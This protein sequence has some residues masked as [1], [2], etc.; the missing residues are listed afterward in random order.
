VYNGYIYVIGGEYKEGKFSCFLDDVYYAHIKEDGSIGNWKATTSLPFRQRGHGCTVHNGY[1]Y[2]TG[3]WFAGR[4]VSHNVLCASI[5]TDGTIGAWDFTMPFFSP[6]DNH[7]T[8]INKEFIYVIAG[9]RGNDIFSDIQY[10]TTK[11]LLSLIP[12]NDKPESTIGWD[13]K[14]DGN[15]K[16]DNIR[17]I[18]IDLNGNVYIAGIG[19]NLVSKTSSIDWWIKKFDSDGKEDTKNW[20]KKIDGNRDDDRISSIAIDSKGNIYVKGYS[21]TVAH[22]KISYYLW[23]KKF[24]K[25]GNEDINNWDKKYK[26]NKNKINDDSELYPFGSHGTIEFDSEDNVYIVYSGNAINETS[27]TDWI[28]KKFNDNGEED[29]ANWNK[30]FDGNSGYDLVLAITIDKKDNIYVSGFGQDLVSNESGYDF[31]IKKFDING[32]ED[33]KNWDKKIDGKSKGENNWDW[34]YSLAID[35]KNN[36]YVGGF[37]G[38][39]VSKKSSYD[40]WIKKFSSSGIEDTKN[41]DKKFDSK[42]KSDNSYSHSD[43]IYSIAIGPNGN[44]YIAGCGDSL[45]NK[46]S[47]SDW[48]IKKFDPNGIEDKVNWDKKIDNNNGSNIISSLAIDKNGDIYAAGKG[49]NLVSPMSGYD[50]WIKKFDSNGLEIKRIEPT[51]FI[52]K[53]KEIYLLSESKLLFNSLSEYLDLQLYEIKSNAFNKKNYYKYNTHEDMG[54]KFSV[55]SYIKS[56]KKK[57]KMY[58]VIKEFFDIKKK[59]I[60]KQVSKTTSLIYYKE[61][62]G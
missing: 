8:I 16:D 59:E 60:D 48:W 4:D 9:N 2:V 27:K 31:W 54:N 35:D 55:F 11:S 43:V 39:L 56:N 17:S 26:V 40:W 15:G 22:G 50:W 61:R 14:I 29:Q 30:K 52:Q 58:D 6:R 57:E 18:A 25:N 12:S 51:S 53:Y 41:W 28:I 13:K 20:D 33:T 49:Q 32:N 21:K 19:E 44:V 47:N 46:K 23:I 37:G 1:V 7:K 34:A 24:D 42:A 3:G 45:V 10:A 36:V 62:K 5:N 38:D